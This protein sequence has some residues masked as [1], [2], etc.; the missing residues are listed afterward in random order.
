MSPSVQFTIASVD[1]AHLNQVLVNLTS[2]PGI[3]A[4]DVGFFETLIKRLL[5]EFTA[6]PTIVAVLSLFAGAVIIA[7][8]VALSTLERRRQVGVMKAIGLKGQRVLAQM[9]LE[10]GIIG[11][12][13]RLL[14]VGI[15]HIASLLLS[16]NSTIP[17]TQSISGGTGS[18]LLGLSHVDSPLAA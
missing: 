11:L 15:G 17:I 14:R 8:T 4:F 3:F 18:L 6:I 16:I 1:D 2:L 10:N 9:V 13:C 12:H 5:N 7:N